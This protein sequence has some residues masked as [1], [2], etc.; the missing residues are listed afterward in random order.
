MINLNLIPH[1][2]KTTMFL[3]FSFVEPEPRQPGKSAAGPHLWWFGLVSSYD[4][5]AFIK[6]FHGSWITRQAECV[7]K[8][9]LSGVMAKIDRGERFSCYKNILMFLSTNI[10]RKYG[11]IKYLPNQ[12]YTNNIPP[13]EKDTDYEKFLSLFRQTVPKEQRGWNNWLFVLREGGG[14]MRR[15]DYLQWI[16][17]RLTGLSHW[18]RSPAA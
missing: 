2:L 11:L 16:I 6:I 15:D 1:L 17:V 13:Q 9:P 18:L 10:E 5:N 8:K 3:P 4:H 7:T 12:T 14:G